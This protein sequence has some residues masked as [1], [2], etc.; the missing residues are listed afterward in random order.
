MFDVSYVI[1]FTIARKVSSELLG[2]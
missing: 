2:F 1:R